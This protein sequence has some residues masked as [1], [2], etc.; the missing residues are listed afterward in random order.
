MCPKASSTNRESVPKAILFVGA[1]QVTS[2]TKDAVRK[3][4][5]LNPLPEGYVFLP[6][7]EFPQ[8]KLT[9]IADDITF[10]M[11]VPSIQVRHVVVQ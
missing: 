3:I 1:D 10:Q 7:P 11:T 4:K 8:V 6:D 5:F 9:D 2:A